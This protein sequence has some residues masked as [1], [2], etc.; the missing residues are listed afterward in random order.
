MTAPS[1]S[2]ISKNY[3]VAVRA[4]LDQLMATS[5]PEMTGKLILWH[6]AP[7][8]GKTTALRALARAWQPWCATQYVSDPERFFADPGY[9]G[10][11]LTRPAKARY[12]PTLDEPGETEAIW[13]LVIAED[14]DE[15]LRSSARRDAGAAL[16]RLLNLTDGILGQG[17][18]FLVLLTTNEEQSRLHPAIT[19]SGRCLTRVEFAPFTV[20]EA[21]HWA[22]GVAEVAGAGGTL[23]DL[24][25]R[26]GDLRR[27]GEVEPRLSTGVYL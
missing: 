25:E 14:A 20:A 1:W 23:A 7:G 24:L 17:I 11:V 2:E 18:N 4:R 8:T 9:M 21:R 6:G 27:F 12:G 16:G 3:P 22:D 19:R 26:R 5:R 13:R 15:Y 10:H